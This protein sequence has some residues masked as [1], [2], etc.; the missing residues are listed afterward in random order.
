[1]LNFR[2]YS[3]EELPAEFKLYLPVQQNKGGQG[4]A[5]QGASALQSAS[6]GGNGNI[7]L[8]ASVSTARIDNVTAPM[9]E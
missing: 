1:M 5:S 6:A 3:E 2:L 4:S 7:D 8:G 9:D